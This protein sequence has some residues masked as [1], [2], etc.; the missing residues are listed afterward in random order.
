L[1]EDVKPERR[2]SFLVEKIMKTL[3]VVT[4]L[5]LLAGSLSAQGA[6][7]GKSSAKASLTRKELKRIRKL[8]KQVLQFGDSDRVRVRLVDHKP[9][10]GWIRDVSDRGIHFVDSAT[11]DG[12][13]KHPWSAKLPPPRF[14][15]FEHIQSINRP[16]HDVWTPIAVGTW[17]GLFGPLGWLTT[18]LMATGGD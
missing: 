11:K 9:M 8:K 6:P 14:L 16:A 13:V 5:L 18:W 15:P 3:S 4:A 12:Q 2:K 7:A 1:T 17:A 10:E